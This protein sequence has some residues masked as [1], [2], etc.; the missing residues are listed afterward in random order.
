MTKTRS[1]TVFFLKEGF[2]D[3]NSFKEDH[4]LKRLDNVVNLPE[5]GVM[6]LS[7]TPAKEPWWKSYW[8][9]NYDLKQTLKGALIFLPVRNRWVALT[10][11]MTYHKLKDESYEYDFGL[12][13]TLN[14]L[15]PEKIK[16]TDILVPE[17]AKRQRIQ[18]PTVD[19]LTF[20]DLTN[21]DSILK[22][23][24]G[25]VK[26]EYTE[27]FKNIT[28]GNSVRISLK[29]KPTE[30][31][32]I[33]EKLIDIYNKNDYKINF[34]SLQNIVPV[35]DPRVLNKLNDKLIEAFNEKDAPFELVLAIPEIFDYSLDY[36]IKYLGAGRSLRSYSE[37]YIYDYRSYLEEKN[38]EVTNYETFKSHRLV[39]RDNNDRTRKEYSI[40]K[41]LLFD[42][43]LDQNT[44]HLCEG[45]WY[46]IETKFVEKLS[47]SLD[48]IFTET[49]NYLHDCEHRKE[50]DYNNSVSD[51]NKDIVINLDRKDISPT[52]QHQVEPCDLI[53]KNKD[54][55][56]FAHIKVSTRSSS[57]SHLFNQGLNSVQLLRSNEEARNKLKKLV[58]K[59]EMKASIDKGKFSVVYGII[60]NKNRSECSKCLPFFSRISLLRTLNVLK[61]MNIPVKVYFIKDN[62]DRK[63]LAK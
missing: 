21:D 14:S 51:L 9:V 34:P 53:Y 63:K 11:G 5:G 37:V 30:I 54:Y 43:E 19:E 31:I 42:C 16:S 38:I 46:Y 24:T 6:Y 52:G 62:V 50:E 27:L 26:D 35:N 10:F 15:N 13:T 8:G 33:C 17:N 18:S 23:M 29:R 48:P 41:S 28:G 40:F 20:F 7:D 45:N 4:K 2:S 36:K 58:K 47:S 25:S 49:N 3:R 60:T 22:K 61:M 12:R 59:D 39:I 56:E 32:H 55:L 1:F 57:L 44:Y